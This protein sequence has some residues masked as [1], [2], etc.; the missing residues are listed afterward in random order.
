MLK[1]RIG[2]IL[3]AVWPRCVKIIAA[4]L[5]VIVAASAFVGIQL[6]YAS[7]AE[8]GG[9]LISIL[10]G[11]SDAINRR[12]A[13]GLIVSSESL[14]EL[15]ALVFDEPRITEITYPAATHI[16]I[17]T[18]LSNVN[19]SLGSGDEIVIRYSEWLD[20]QYFTVASEELI[21]IESA[22]PLHA[23]RMENGV[24]SGNWREVHSMGNTVY[25]A[26]WFYDYIVENEYD[27]TFIEILLPAGVKPAFEVNNSLA[28]IH[29]YDASF[30]SLSANTTI[31][32]I[33]LEKV[34]AESISA[35][36]S[37]GSISIA[38]ARIDALSLNSSS[39]M[40]S[41]G[42]IHA[43]TVSLNTSSG[44]ITLDGAGFERGSVNSASGGITVSNSSF[45]SLS[46]NTASGRITVG[47]P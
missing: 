8:F 11:A 23:V 1:Q 25:H 21:K 15:H 4:L 46:A 34:E 43:S 35:N 17:D 39:G 37:T 6:Y 38:D 27:N 31:G 24:L 36:S 12:E 18:M 13:A 7:A 32:D 42:N 14:D 9:I 45:K 33:L 26:G 22:F 47:L 28:D 30:A 19:V 16:R 5:A 40:I 10:P 29:F 3:E 20:G 44:R 2:S 41:V